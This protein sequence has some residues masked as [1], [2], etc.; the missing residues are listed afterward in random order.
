MPKSPCLYYVLRVRPE[1]LKIIQDSVV[2]FVSINC[3]TIVAQRK[4]TPYQPRSRTVER[5]RTS[6]QP[7]TNVQKKNTKQIDVFRFVCDVIISRGQH[8]S[9]P[10]TATIAT[11]SPSNLKS[12]CKVISWLLTGTE[13]CNSPPLLGK[14]ITVEPA[15][16][17]G[18]QQ[19]WMPDA[20]P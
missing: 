1:Y 20:A 10:G 18:G 15:V 19:G 3:A 8:R 2:N 4:D 14:W 12:A 6:Y 5:D 13:S 16:E 7:A 9:Y 11:T 17:I